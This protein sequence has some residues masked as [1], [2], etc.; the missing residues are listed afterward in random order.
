MQDY[1]YSVACWQWHFGAARFA[2][3]DESLAFG[4]TR[5]IFDE[6]GTLLPLRYNQ[7]K[8]L[9]NASSNESF[10]TL[11]PPRLYLEEQLTT[12]SPQRV[13]MATWVFDKRSGESQK[14]S[15]CSS[16]RLLPL[17]F[18]FVIVGDSVTTTEHIP[19][20]GNL[21]SIGGSTLG[22]SLSLSSGTERFGP[23]PA[24]TTLPAIKSLRSKTLVGS[25]ISRTAYD[26]STWGMV[27]NDMI[28]A[29]FGQFEFLPQSKRPQ[30]DILA[31][32]GVAWGPSALYRNTPQINTAPFTPLE[33]LFWRSENV[34]FDEWGGTNLPTAKQARA[35]PKSMAGLIQTFE[36]EL[37]LTKAGS[38]RDCTGGIWQSAIQEFPIEK[39]CRSRQSLGSPL[40]VI[41]KNILVQMYF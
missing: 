28:L 1:W 5:S 18:D 17:A 25:F 7:R 27:V 8:K 20:P 34:Y 33:D 4:R 16:I 2:W 39:L 22:T 30:Y 6:D 15:K 41:K 37:G 13:L 32:V 26:L 23:N 19:L 3:I 40:T 14:G 21:G 36:N 12:V 10:W 9:R 24:V 38:I 35:V 31:G 11:P 29:C